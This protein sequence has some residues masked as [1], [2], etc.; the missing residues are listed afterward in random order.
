MESGQE[1]SF[2]ETMIPRTLSASALH[3]AE[4]CMSRYFAEN[5]ERGRGE[6]NSAAN[7]GS[8]VHGALEYFVKAVYLD[9]VHPADGKLDLLKQYY[10]ISFMTEFKTA[11]TDSPE[12]T[13]GWEMLKKWWQRTSFEGVEVLSCE[14]KE[15]FEVK[16]PDGSVI[17]FNYIWDRFDKI[18]PNEYKVV[19][20]KT[21]RWAIKPDDL[22]AKIQARFYGLAVQIKYPDAEKIWVEFDQLRHDPVGMVFTREDNVA[23]WKFLKRAVQRIYE[24]DEGLAGET[25][26]SEC[27]WCVRKIDC[28]KVRAN[29]NVGGIHT[30][31][32]IEDLIERRAVLEYQ[33][34]AAKAALD[35]VDKLIIAEA[36]QLDQLEFE[37]TNYKANIGA[38]ATR[39]VDGE[40]AEQILGEQLFRK[41]GSTSITMTDIDKLLKGNELTETQKKQLEGIIYRKVGEAKVKTVKQSPF[42]KE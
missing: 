30:I 29:A 27:K 5:I 35:E 42:D 4:L 12:Y 34:G 21:I 18:G 38:R 7:L 16:F 1:T 25:L 32:S 2:G 33:A 40:R 13:D 20:Y 36:Q 17:P 19:D 10:D 37:S 23:T 11:E 31:T 8:A 14:V 3:V 41:Y 39:A 26:N 24:Y 15:F 28:N 22:S 9:K 6:E